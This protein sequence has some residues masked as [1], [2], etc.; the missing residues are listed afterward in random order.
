MAELDTRIRQAEHAR[1][2]PAQAAR[3]RELVSQRQTLTQELTALQG[4][5]DGVQAELGRVESDIAV[6]DARSERDAQRLNTVSSVKDAQGLESELASLARRKSDLED[7]QLELM[8]RLE[9][10]ESAVAAQAALVAEVNDEGSRLSAEG[11]TA[12]AEATAQLEAAT[13]DR[14]AIAAELPGELIAAYDRAALRS[15]GAAALR[16][17]TCEGLQH[18]PVRHRSGRHAAGG[19]GCRGELPRVRVHPGAHRRVGAVTTAR[20][21]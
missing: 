18:G 11:K 16:A 3:V 20:D 8:E 6:V 14:A 12:V 7:M 4:S 5:R 21:R 19:R 1:S 17:Q 13:R 2:S 10:A 9:E 15:V